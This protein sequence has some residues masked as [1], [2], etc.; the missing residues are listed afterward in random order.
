M[1]TSRRSF[2][3]SASTLA[4]G[5]SLA[6]TSALSYARIPGAND[7]LAVGH[8]GIGARGRG[9]AKIASR[10]KDK[11]NL[12]MT[13]V[14]D[15]WSVNREAAAAQ[16][17][18]VYG[19]APQSFQY[20]DDLLALKNVDVVLI[21]TADFQHATHL[22]I[23]AQAGKDVYCEKPMANNLD[24]A[25]AARDAVLQSGR[26]CQIGT[27]HR[28]E[29]Y[30]IAVKNLLATGV[31]G[32]L[33]KVEIVW[34][35]HG[36]RWRGRPEVRQIRE[37]DTDWRKWLLNKPY[38]PFDPRAYFEFRLYRDFSAGIADQWLCHAID[39]I[40][41][42]FDDGAP[43]SVVS[44]GGVF[45]WHDGRENP[46]TFQTLIESH[47]GYLVS[48]STSFGNDSDSFTRLMGKQATLVNIGGEGSPRWKVVEEKGNHEDNPLIQRAERYVTL[49]GST[50]MAPTYIDDNVTYHMD[51]FLD[52][53]RSRKAP[54]ATVK[55]G[56]AHSVTDIMA[57]KSY[58]EG[59]KLYWHAG[60][61][62]I[63]A[64]A[65]AKT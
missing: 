6:G 64:E 60:T 29:P 37:Q 65:P 24:E 23:A 46:D 12:E 26:I 58:W 56:F 47:K 5:G 15:L 45:A 34:N 63:S 18:S 32:D 62:T 61:E 41:Y 39:L 4:L 2:L 36:P 42:F 51:N 49:P 50:A 8:I 57:T 52:C 53:V 44:A 55:E 3:Q 1:T 33:S 59:R 10:L 13:A 21:S 20:M 48:Y 7:R 38:R 14:C 17:A 9:L 27:Q 43:R 16:A 31:L 40:N 25:K 35:Y 28:S 19:R 54:H 30:Q 22:R 11:Q